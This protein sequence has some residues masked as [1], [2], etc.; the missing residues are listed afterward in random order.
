MIPEISEV[1]PQVFPIHHL[2]WPPAPHQ[3]PQASRK[4]GPFWIGRSLGLVDY[5]FE[6]FGFTFAEGCPPPG[7]IEQPG[8]KKKFASSPPSGRV[9]R[10]TSMKR[11]AELRFQKKGTPFC[12]PAV[13]KSRVE[14][15]EGAKFPRPRHAPPSA[16]LQALEYRCFGPRQ[17]RRNSVPRS[18]TPLWFI[19]FSSCESTL[20]GDALP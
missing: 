2:D 12:R 6:S 20:G 15:G 18:K 10:K 8:K 4:P 17:R 13:K 1:P 5:L 7:G 9:R 3:P 14:V 11:R 19:V 16:S